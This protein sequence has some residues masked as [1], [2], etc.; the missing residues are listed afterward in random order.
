MRQAVALGRI[1]SQPPAANMVEM[2]WDEELAVRAQQ[3]L[4]GQNMAS[5]W[6]SEGPSSYYETKP[7]FIA[8]AISKW[9]NEEKKFHYGRI[10]RGTVG[11]YT[12]IVWAETNL[13]GCGYAYY[14]DPVGG[15]TKNYVCNYG[16]SGNVQGELPYE[17]GYTNCRQ[18][19]LT[20]SKSYTGLCVASTKGQQFEW[21]H[22]LN[23]N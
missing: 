18:Y 22:F 3:F 10:T 13:V 1:T 8:D 11:H 15:Y 2:K 14:L 19:G 21:L 5:S 17:K 7:D 16:P 6:G 4:V 9:F 20:E 23:Y 12:Q